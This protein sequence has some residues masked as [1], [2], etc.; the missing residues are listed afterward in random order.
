MRHKWHVKRG[1]LKIHVAV[2]IKKKKIVSLEVTSEEVHD[3]KMLKKMVDNASK[4]NVVKRVLADG[5]YDSKKNFQYLHDNG[6][7]KQLLR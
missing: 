4:N 6:V 5:T 2:D 7:S 3:S 1:Y